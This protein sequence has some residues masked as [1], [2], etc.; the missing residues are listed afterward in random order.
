MSAMGIELMP[1]VAGMQGIGDFYV[2]PADSSVAQLVSVDKGSFILSSSRL[3]MPHPHSLSG[4]ELSW[5]TLS[6]PR[7]SQCHCRFRPSHRE[8][9]DAEL[10]RTKKE[11]ASQSH[12]PRPG[13]VMAAV[14]EAIYKFLVSSTFSIHSCSIVVRLHIRR[15]S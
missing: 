8:Q 9:L 13:A 1:G 5:R 14:V 15:F 4:R 10:G 12:P 3:S 2:N 11:P 6:P 7:Q